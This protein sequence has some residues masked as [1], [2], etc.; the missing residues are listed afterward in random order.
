MLTIENTDRISQDSIP[1][2]CAAD[3]KY[4]MQLGV[5][6]A[7]VLDNLS[8]DR[9]LQ[10]YVIDGNIS[11]DNKRK[12]SKIIGSRGSIVYLY[13]KEEMLHGVK[14]SGHIS[15]ATYYRLLIPDL[16]PNLSKI[17]YL[18]CDLV[19]NRNIVDLWEKDVEE[20]FLRAVPEMSMPTFSEGI[21]G[22]EKLGYSGNEMYFNAGVLLINLQ[23]WREQ[24]VSEAAIRHIQEH[25]DDIRYWDQDGLNIA[26]SN[27]WIPLEP[28]WNR[29][30]HIHHYKSW[31]QSPFNEDIYKTLMQNPAIAHFTTK[32]KPWNSYNHPDKRMFYRYLDKTSWAGWRF[33]LWRAIWNKG[34]ENWSRSKH[35]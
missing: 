1:V 28:I 8:K 26:L 6:V 4:S 15:I 13:P 9:F 10:L 14:I 7:S 12:I 24:K 30:S 5:M 23:K 2:I 17:L 22:Y 33:P 20:C 19:V 31:Q 27:Q 11:E 34:I 25:I 32:F 35:A 3:D 29:T 16:L 21:V 18:D